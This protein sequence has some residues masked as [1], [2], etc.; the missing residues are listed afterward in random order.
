MAPRASTPKRARDKPPK[1]KKN[2]TV[3]SVI[4]D[5]VLES[6]TEETARPKKRKPNKR[7]RRKDELEHPSVWFKPAIASDLWMPEQM[8]LEAV[9]KP[10]RPRKPRKPRRGNRKRWD[11]GKAGNHW[12][13][14]KRGRQS[15][16]HYVR[17]R[18]PASQ[19]SVEPLLTSW[20]E[21]EN[22][23]DDQRSHPWRTKAMPAA[24]VS[25]AIVD[26]LKELKVVWEPDDP[27]NSI[28]KVRLYPS[29]CQKEKLDQMFAANRAVYNK[30]VGMSKIDRAT[31]VAVKGKD[32]MT[33]A[34]LAAKY[35]PIAK[36]KTMDRY[37]RNKKG[38]ARHRE[39][40]DEVRDSAF[41][42]F[43]KAVKSS[44]ALF[45]GKLR[46]DESTT[47]PDLKFKSK[48]APS[49]T[50]EFMSRSFRVVITEGR[51][52]VHFKPRYFGFEN[53]D[54][55]EVHERL[56]E[57]TMSVRL[58]RLR[59]GVYYL[60]VPRKKE[61]TRSM[62]ERICAIDPG[63][64]NFATVYDPDGRTLSVKD[65]RFVLKKKF[66]AVDAMKSALAKM[67]NESKAFHPT[68]I[69]TKRKKDRRHAK[70]EKHRRRYR[71][72]RCIRLT[73]RKATRAVND[74]HHKLASWL[75]ANYYNVLLPSFQTSEMVQKY[76][77]EEA[78]DATPATCSDEE[79]VT[80]Q[81]RKLRS[82][83]A[84]AMLA[85]A[86]Y[87]FKILLKYKM[88]RAGG[89]LVECEEE[90]TSKT[91]SS[92][93]EIKN[94]LGGNHTF[95]CDRCHVVLD[96]DVSAAKNIFHKNMSMLG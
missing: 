51:D 82:S 43:K 56:P 58:Q 65:A 93:G 55:I 24:P 10:G 68:K 7:R 52:R 95:R 72:R 5:L 96:R 89:R 30:L 32:K 11:K 9:T 47:Y 31:R 29:T 3:N 61:F 25:R 45:F 37:F 90:Y 53:T 17:K 66:E 44:I 62:T 77:V 14:L 12:R 48:F 87:R 4:G 36:L 73:S 78:S 35:R 27:V 71:L 85:Q 94:N 18:V 63:V 83:T 8:E 69:R 79:R 64:R 75:S 19:R 41:G 84:R 13:R 42:D 22:F 16:A 76:L 40:P 1:P 2:R 6:D 57:L 54:G 26:E 38:L 60:I 34:Q 67:D 50:I 15:H 28:L 86:H 33:Q 46:R 81:K 39:V 91:C 59:E 21:V 80:F 74:M 20:F 88:E 70:S 49:N 23:T 92:C